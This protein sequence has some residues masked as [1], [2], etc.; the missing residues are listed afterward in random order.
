M[1]SADKKKGA[2]V[3]TSK[4]RPVTGLPA[5]AMGHGG[6][7][8]ARVAGNVTPKSVGQKVRGSHTGRPIMVL[9][10]VLG[11]RWTLRVLWELGQTRASFRTLR[12]K[13]D[14]V[15]P[16][17]LNKRLKQLRELGLL[18][19]DEQGY[20]LTTL[21]KELTAQ[22]IGLD[23]WANKWANNEYGDMM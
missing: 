14:D 4:E 16:T 12:L 17:L 6:E 15:S 20:G 2:V 13:C 19:L 5:S 10:D 11:Q 9:L 1:P 23:G 22:L 3:K 21:G 7:N 18:D 8:S